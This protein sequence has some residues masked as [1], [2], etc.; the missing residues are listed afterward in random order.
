MGLVEDKYEFSY[1]ELVML[2]RNVRYVAEKM[3]KF[4]D[5]KSIGEIYFAYATLK[6]KIEK[7]LERKMKGDGCG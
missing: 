1:E 3:E 5:I 2:L 6:A 4:F 7:I